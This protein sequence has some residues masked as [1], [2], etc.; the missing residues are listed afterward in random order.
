[1][2]DLRFER[3]S[4][5]N[6]PHV[7]E[8]YNETFKDPITLDRLRRKY[9]TS[10]LG[11]RHL[12]YLA[13]DGGTPVAFYGAL[14]QEFIADG[15]V[16]FGVHTCDSITRA[17]YRGR[18]VHRD[19]AEQA[20]RL[21]KNHGVRL[22]YAFHSEATFHACRKLGWSTHARMRGFKIPVAGLPVAALCRRLSSFRP[23]YDAH[24]RRVLH[25]EAD[26]RPFVNSHYREGAMCVRYSPAF[27]A[28]KTFSHNA[29]VS[30]GPTRAWV[31]AA[32][33]LMV[34]DVEF[35]REDDIVAG[36]A[37]LRR[38]AR[39]LGCHH[40]L[41]QTFPGSRLETSLSR[42]WRGFDTWLVGYRAFDSTLPVDRWRT[43]FG[44]LD[45]F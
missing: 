30:V 33:G 39:R 26:P 8:L 40:L 37:G 44:D 43:N 35:D 31:K 10:Y 16:F 12:T 6:L 18:G 17:G 24:L 25:A 36:V 34:G 9:D 29:V 2:T 27:F 20:Y 19:L 7:L 14:P 4:D 13:Y 11:L 42:H 1:M 22:V 21:M 5:S 38:L 15:E 41:F 32:G 3:L 45:T 23:R 28:Y